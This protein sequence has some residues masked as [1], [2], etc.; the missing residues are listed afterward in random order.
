M[1]PWA[2]PLR[3]AILSGTLASL[4]STAAL[5][6]LARAEGKGTLQPA[7]ATSH[8]LNGE[9]AGRFKGADLAHTG[10]GLATHHAAT[11][12]WAAIFE[13]W[14]DT[15]A[16]RTGA[17]L[18][19]DSAAMAAIAAAVDYLATPRRFTPGWEQVLSKPAM[20]GAYAAMALGLAGGAAIRRPRA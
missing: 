20:A 17:A 8:W 11:L 5:A 1:H 16:P 19:R 3:N 13:A 15:R 4:A 10:T 6:L 12:F 2:R 7:N 18:L 9:R 14:L